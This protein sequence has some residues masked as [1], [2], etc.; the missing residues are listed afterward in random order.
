MKQKLILLAVTVLLC[1]ACKKSSTPKP[2]TNTS[3]VILLSK[4]TNTLAGDPYEGKPL[5][6]FTYNGKQLS[7][8]VLYN[9]TGVPS[10]D[11]IETDLF[12]YDNQGHLTGT[13]INH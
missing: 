13:T 1:N 4:V 9:Y 12:N 7:K 2:T 3:P 11:D 8:A 6:E 10:S 5:A